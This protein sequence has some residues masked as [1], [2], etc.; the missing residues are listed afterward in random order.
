MVGLAARV[1]EGEGVAGRVLDSLGVSLAETR[2]GVE[3][4]IGRADTQSA[5]SSITLSPRL[6]RIIELAID[7][8]RQLGQGQIGTEHL[9]LG[10]LRDG[11]NNACEILKAKGIALDIVRQRVIATIKEQEPPSASPS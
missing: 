4:L 9:L 7:E 2:R 8:S 5:P 11:G 1:R 10:L 6:K 3:T